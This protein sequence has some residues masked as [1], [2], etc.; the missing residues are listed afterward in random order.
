MFLGWRTES[1]IDGYENGKPVTREKKIPR[2]E[3]RYRNRCVRVG[4][5][6]LQY[7]PNAEPMGSAAPQAEAPQACPDSSNTDVTIDEFETAADWLN[8]RIRAAGPQQ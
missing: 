5:R 6:I 3:T 7:G 4:Y 2:F 8:A 1:V